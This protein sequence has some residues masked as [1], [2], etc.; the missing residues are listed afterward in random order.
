M[1]PNTFWKWLDEAFSEENGKGSNQRLGRFAALVC[2]QVVFVLASVMCIH[3]GQY[4]PML[5]MFDAE[6]LLVGAF[7]GLNMIAT[8][9]GKNKP[10]ADPKPVEG[11][12]AGSP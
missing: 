6:L 1:E 7:F 10:P 3:R 5:A 4:Q 2:S 8:G 9:W 11:A 12:A